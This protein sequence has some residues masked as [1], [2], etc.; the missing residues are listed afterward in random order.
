[1]THR[2]GIFGASGFVGSALCERLFFDGRRDFLPFV[3]SSGNAWR[4]ARFPLAMESVDLLDGEQV[5]KAVLACDV[6]VNC[7]LASGDTR[8]RS[9]RNLVNAMKKARTRRFIHLSSI[10]VYGQ[11]PAADTVTEAAAIAPGNN[12]YGILKQRQD[13][14]IEELRGAGIPYFILCPGNIS[15]PYSPFMIGL[16]ERLARGPLPLVDAGSSPSNLIHVDNLVEAILVAAQSDVGGGERYFVNEIQPIPWRRV[17]D[18][19]ASSLGL[20]AAYVEVKRDQVV[21]LLDPSEPRLGF[22]G[23][24]RIGMSGEVRAVLSKMPLF[25]NLND[26]AVNVFSSLPPRLQRRVRERVTWPIRID[27]AVDEPT[28]EDR[29]VKVQARR[30]HHSPRKLQESLGWRPPLSYEEGLETTACW[31]RFAGH[32]H[33]VTAGSRRSAS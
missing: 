16:A 7:A 32:D 31:L 20:E 4:I 28:L 18:D 22:G 17:F 14:L 12:R 8:A 23:S 24:L 13:E 25:R 15:G 3:H 19:L 27:K 2:L 9:I 21:P 33:R 6:V 11:D 10:A 5:Q 30:F 26:F 1:M 29:Y